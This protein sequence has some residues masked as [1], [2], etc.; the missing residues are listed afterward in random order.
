MENEDDNG[1]I[2]RFKKFA[3]ESNSKFGDQISEWRKMRDFAC[4][5]QTDATYGG[6][7][8]SRY[9]ALPTAYITPSTLPICSGS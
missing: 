3:E 2:D 7:K 1:V 8:T 6:M 9:K 5:D 4:G